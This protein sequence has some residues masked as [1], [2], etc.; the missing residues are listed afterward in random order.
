[1]AYITNEIKTLTGTNITINDSDQKN[2]VDL[3]IQGNAIQPNTLLPSGYTQVEYIESTNNGGQY[4][5]TGVNADKKLRV[6]FDGA[7][8]N[9]GAFGTIYDNG[10][11][12]YVRYH[13]QA[14]STVFRF[15]SYTTGQDLI[16]VDTNRHLF[17]M[18]VPNGKTYVDGTLYNKSVST[19]DT[20]LNFW[21]FKRNSNTASLQS[22]NVA[23]LYFC[24]IYYNGA[25]V[26]NF[27]PCINNSTGKAG[28]YDLVNNIFYGNS[29]TGDFNYGSNISLPNPSF[30]IHINTV[31]GKQN[32]EIRRKNLWDENYV[33]I[34][35]T[36][37][38]KPIYV[39][40]GNFTLSSNIPQG[41]SGDSL[42]LLAGNVS[43]GAN[44]AV[45]GVDK[46]ISRTQTSVD[47]Y[48]TVVYRGGGN[49][50]DPREYN[51][52]LEKG[53]TLTTYEKYDGNTYEINLG[54]NLYN[55]TMSEET[56]RGVTRSADNQRLYFD[57]TVESTGNLDFP[58]SPQKF[59]AGTYFLNYE[60][61]SGTI[62][63]TNGINIY[64][65]SNPN[66]G[67]TP[68]G[69][70]NTI[71]YKETLQLVLYAPSKIYIHCYGQTTNTKYEDVVVKYQIT[72]LKDDYSFAPYKTPIEL[73]SIPNTD[74][75]DNIYKLKHDSINLFNSSFET[76][77]GFN[78]NMSYE[79]G[80]IT[81][82]NTSNDSGAVYLNSSL[83][84][85]LK[86]GTYTFIF[87]YV[88][89]T[90]SGANIRIS[91]GNSSM[92][93]GTDDA[94]RYFSLVSS[95]GNM[96]NVVNTATLTE[97]KTINKWGI[98]INSG[99]TFNN[100]KFRLYIVEGTYTANDIPQYEFY[101][102][103]KGTW[104]IE[105]QVGKVVLDGTQ[106]LYRKDTGTSGYY[107]FD[108]DIGRNVINSSSISFVAPIYCNRLIGVTRGNT[109]SRIEGV[110]PT[111]TDYSYHT[112]NLYIEAIS[113]MTTT[114]ANTWFSNN[115]TIVYYPY[116]TPLYTQITDDELLSQLNAIE[117][118]EKLNNIAV[119]SGDLG[120]PIKLSYYSTDND[121]YDAVYSQDDRN[122]L[123]IWFNDV[124]LENAPIKC[125]KITRTARILPNDGNKIFGLNNFISTSLEV[126]L[127]NVDLE[128]I[129]NQ[130]KI[131]IGTLIDEQNDT[132]EYIPLG[133]FNIQDTPTNDN[134][135]ITL[136]LRDNRVKFD[137]NYNAQ[138]LIEANGG[139]A[140]KKQILDDICSQ[141]GVTNTIDSF[142]GQDELVGIYDNTI[143]A[144]TYVSYLM[145]QAGLIPVI[146]REGN[147]KAIDLSKLYV[148]K[149]PL[150]ILETGFQ[151]GEPYKI[152]RVVYESGII[153]YET[154]NDETL[155]TL[156]I[157]AS[158]PYITDQEQVNYILEK[159]QNFKIDSVITK[160]VLGNPAIDPYDIIRIYNDLDNS[161]DTI[162]ETLA[163]TTYTYNGKHRD[164]FDTQIGK[165][166]RTENVT[167][168]SESTFQKY[169]KAL[170]DN[171]EGEITLEV[172]QI[173]GNLTALNK[174]LYGDEDAGTQ[175]DINILSSQIT[176]KANAIE[177]NIYKDKVDN[178]ETNGVDKVQTTSVLINNDGLNVATNTSKISTQ[179]TNNS[180]EIRDSGN[181][182]LAFFGYNEAEGIS[183]SRMDNLTV[184]KYFIAGNHRVETYEESGEQRTGWFYIGG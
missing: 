21:L 182:E 111:T 158:N 128:D 29:G 46:T 10:G 171:I 65:Y 85:T 138:P 135:K 76:I 60:I 25:L 33:N 165:E 154:S 143:T 106:T 175:G 155:D 119:S 136:K 68:V 173:S 52:M 164:I 151:I 37:I 30:P 23:K 126:I 123:K 1:M 17:D 146:D 20:T 91:V 53:S 152:D 40:E 36:L 184:R 4:I 44:S 108:V 14:T 79:N 168:K 167:L 131:S 45:N 95:S 12:S 113:Q 58:L 19:F 98:Y 87:Q 114:Q 147:L 118:K 124:E 180:F 48:V 100:F 69:R 141:A 116:K 16:T 2:I 144:T 71:G 89:G 35:T 140:S 93:I 8:L 174:Q 160:N 179:I 112:F 34:S 73:L 77:T 150:S 7:I 129:Q 62:T 47:G 61:E 103:K 134:G 59:E 88:D 15:Y 110:A 105:K 31:T 97:D 96:S 5:D 115:N 72:K 145:E 63:G 55:A 41:A 172:G 51:T 42:F 120:S 66:N 32:V 56:I 170:I 157:D 109:Y 83:N 90:M 133:V 81:L 50:L 121:Y 169:A 176:Q 80:I 137:F 156:Y 177:F 149:I 181:T 142:N 94:N 78:V 107:R 6:V 13:L 132:Y 101:G 70:I 82:N 24:Q 39:G 49:Y 9:Q 67:R 43:S 162:F 57:G 153:K 166:Q 92:S 122:D 3:Q 125:E 117:L 104:L 84:D 102:A 148:W 75:K 64:L 74:Y 11:G 54:K 161:N 178:I 99:I 26:R 139:T 28:L 159:L 183:I 163:N 22:S 38:Y 18:D 27:V 127:H 86:S 130:V